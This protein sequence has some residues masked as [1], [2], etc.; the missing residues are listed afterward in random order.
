MLHKIGQVL[1][2]VGVDVRRARVATLGA[3]AVDVFYV[4]DEAGEKLDPELS[5]LV[6]KRIL[7]AL[8]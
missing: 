2:D 7:A 6:K 5:A 1:A 8:R 3:E 4:V